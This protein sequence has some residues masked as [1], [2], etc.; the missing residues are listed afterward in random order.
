MSSLSIE[1]LLEANNEL[2]QCARYG[3]SEDLKE[4]LVLGAN[5]NYQDESGTT[6]LHKAAANGEVECMIILKQ[7]GA[8]HVSNAQGNYPLHWAAQNGKFG[9]VKYLIDNYEDIDMLV[10]NSFGRSILTEAFQSQNTDVIELCLSHSSATEEKLMPSTTTTNTNDTNTSDDTSPTQN[11]TDT[12]AITHYMKFTT[13]LNTPNPLP[14]LTIRELPIER[15]DNPFGTDHIPED[16]T[17]GLGIWPASIIAARWVTSI[18]N[19]GLFKDKTVVELG[20]GCGLPGL[21]AGRSISI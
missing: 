20:A 21:A 16:D 3:E 14:I 10:Q 11:A 13:D 19:K 12:N 7:Q 2:L 15:A 1:E 9:A 8:N 18:R 4:L 17:T 6:A 5:V